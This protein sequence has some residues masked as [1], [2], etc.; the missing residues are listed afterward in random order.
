MKIARVQVGV[1]VEHRKKL[2]PEK[3]ESESESELELEAESKSTPG[4]SQG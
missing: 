3:I 1:R 4:M 2:I